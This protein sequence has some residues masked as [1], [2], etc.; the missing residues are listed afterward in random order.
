MPYTPVRHEEVASLVQAAGQPLLV[1]VRP[2]AGGWANSNYL[3]ELRDG[4]RLVLKIWNG[5]TPPEV[6]G[7]VANTLWL[8]RHGVPTPAPLPLK[9]GSHLQIRDGLT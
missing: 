8:A 3:L 7:L 2:L 9:G 1:A 5:R 6:E 4:S